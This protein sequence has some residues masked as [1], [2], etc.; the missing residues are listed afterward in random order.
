[1]YKYIN[2][3]FIPILKAVGEIYMYCLLQMLH[4]LQRRRDIREIWG[5][6]HMVEVRHG[7]GGV[8]AVPLF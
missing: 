6:R 5:C 7:E 3:F 1:M 2:V 8:S 4:H